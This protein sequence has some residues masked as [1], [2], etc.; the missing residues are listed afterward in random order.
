[1]A[2]DLGL[3]ERKKRETRA[4]LIRTAFELCAD[5]G[6]DDVT[7]ADIAAGANVSTRTFFNYF[8]SK[9]EA[10][11]GGTEPAEMFVEMLAERPDD[12]PLWKALRSAVAGVLA[13]E[14][15]P[16]RDLLEQYRLVSQSPSLAHQQ[17]A[18]WMEMER[19]VVGEVA[20]RTRTDASE[21]FP[22]LVVAAIVAA[23][24]VAIDHWIDTPT[25]VPLDAVVDEALVA[26]SDGLQHVPHAAHP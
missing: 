13:F 26:F 21:L 6:V 19:L 9:E 17:M 11:V 22:R 20:R 7:V 1:M 18:T 3:R 25:D 23:F 24:R 5:R 10:F 14:G 4:A 8:S 15:T 12:E 2:D 16:E